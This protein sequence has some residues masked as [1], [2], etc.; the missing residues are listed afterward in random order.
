MKVLHLNG[1]V[2]GGV[3]NVALTLHEKLLENKI[4]SFIFLTEKKMIRNEV[5]S[6]S[7]I[8]LKRFKNFI[9]KILK[10]ILEKNNQTSTLGI[11]KSVEINKI[12]NEIKPD[13][14]HLHWIGNELL[15][16]NQLLTIKKPIV[17][18]LHDMWFF[19]PHQHYYSGSFKDK[20]YISNIFSNFL[21]SQKK[22]LNFLDLKIVATSEWIKKQVEKSKL[23]SKDKIYKIPLG[24][25]FNK[26]Y[27]ENKEESKKYFKFNLKKK[28][29]LFSAMGLNN[30][31]KGLDIL[32]ETLKLINFDYELVISSDVKPNFTL[33]KEYRFIKNMNDI[34]KRRK[35]YSACDVNVSPSRLEAFG[36][37][38]LEASACGTPS[39]IFENTGLQEIIINKNNGYVAKYL[40]TKDFANGINW[41][42]EAS[43]KKKLDMKQNR[44]Y[45]MK[46]FDINRIVENYIKLYD[47]KTF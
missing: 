26:W 32:N 4:E 44:N 31:R 25:D 17:I 18:T 15:S 40:D 39:V 14:I 8:N 22:K 37:V 5:I 30:N 6:K 47:K 29:I 7:N 11:F 28:T 43:D 12:I 21:I 16:I 20:N 13:V 10:K 27:Q 41:T 2:A 1:T 34:D 38:A 24:L 45:L 19:S 35:L 36:L 33:Y 23:Y 3:F 9:A 42:L 46:K